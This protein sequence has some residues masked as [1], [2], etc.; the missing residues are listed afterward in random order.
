MRIAT[1][2][3]RRE[4]L[5]ASLIV[6]QVGRAA[7]RWVDK[8]PAEWTPDDIQTVL[9]HSAWVREAPLELDPSAAGPANKGKVGTGRMTEFNILVRWESALPIRLARRRTSLPNGGSGNYVI[10][11]SRL[12]VAFFA[13]AL[14]Y[15][16]SESANKTEICEYLA[17]YTLVEHT[18]KTPLRVQRTEWLESDFSSRVE[19]VFLAATI[20]SGFPIGTST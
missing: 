7:T 2:R 12:P 19:L 3:T 9:N 13:A 5:A 14:G 1:S 20:P 10:S 17:K 6:P 16:A 18:D 15:P 8:K 11:L 4:F